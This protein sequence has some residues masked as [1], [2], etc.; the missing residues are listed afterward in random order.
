M[1]GRSDEGKMMVNS[2]EMEISLDQKEVLKSL[3]T[4]I[5]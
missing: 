2:T 3:Q 4:R 5:E 1:I